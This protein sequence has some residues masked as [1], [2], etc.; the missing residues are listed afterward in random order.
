MS[1]GHACRHSRGTK[2][3]GDGSVRAPSKHKRAREGRMHG[4]TRGPRARKNAARESPRV[5]PKHRPSL[6]NGVNGLYALSRVYRAFC[7]RRPAETLSRDLTPA[8]GRQ[9]HTTSPSAQR[10]SSSDAAA[11]IASRAH[12]R[13]DRDTPLVSRKSARMCE[14]AV[15]A[16]P[17]VAG[18]EP[19]TP[20]RRQ[21]LFRARDSSGVFLNPNSCKGFEPEPSKEGSG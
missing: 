11:S 7:H 9:D 10:H 19:V 6:R 17:P 16:K 14:R 5:R 2:C 12:V 8:S 18:T 15:V 1:G 20:Q 3:P 13:D 21:S 4:R